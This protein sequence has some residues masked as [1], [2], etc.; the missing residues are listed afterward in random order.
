M[1]KEKIA[2]IKEEFIAKNIGSTVKFNKLIEEYKTIKPFKINENIN[3]T[4]PDIDFTN[5]LL[6]IVRS[7]ST[8][9]LTETFKSMKI[10]LNDPNVEKDLSDGNIGTPGRIAKMWTAPSISDNSELLSGRWTKKPRIASFPNTSEK[11]F[12]ITKRIDLVAVCSHH[13]APF[14]SKFR[15]DSY[16]VVSYIP[17]T[18][19]LGISKLQKIAKWISARGWLQEDLTKVVYDEIAQ[20]AETES[21][22]VK[23][24]NIVHTCESL[25]GAQSHDGCF[26]TEYYGGDFNDKSLRDT[27]LAQ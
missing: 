23:F 25:R 7:A 24:Y 27:V 14:S 6:F 26:T 10:D 15:S 1:T 4:N 16:A 18:R 22:F 11:K 5:D 17:D 3:E 12:P 13:A 21:V 2:F 8:Y 20:V 9:D 19:V